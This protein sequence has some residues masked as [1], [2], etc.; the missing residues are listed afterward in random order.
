MLWDL[1]T[2]LWD[3][4]LLASHQAKDPEE[5]A[6]AA[7]PTKTSSCLKWFNMFNM[8]LNCTTYKDYSND[9]SETL[10]SL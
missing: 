6:G 9:S 8:F 2:V 7:T 1:K 4:I 3:H 10:Y 5:M